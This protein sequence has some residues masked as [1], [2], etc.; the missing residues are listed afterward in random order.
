M[1]IAIFCTLIVALGCGSKD[2]AEKKADEIGEQARDKASVL[3]RAAEAHK[4]KAR[5]QLRDIANGARAYWDD[6]VDTTS[7]AIDAIRPHAASAKDGAEGLVLRGQQKATEVARMAQA[8]GPVL[9]DGV[10]F[11]P[12]YQKADDPEAV[13]A[14]IGDMPRSE[15]IDG[16]TVGFKPHS[17]RQY[18]VLWRQGDHLVGFVYT[19]LTDIVIEQVIKRAP[20][21]IR[22]VRSIF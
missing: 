4:D 19:S 13:D 18:L 15:V 10:G 12:I 7:A 22:T 3:A 11:K 5:D 9:A 17:K 6:T 14:V 2:E 16:L 21:L 1:R 8:V 20:D